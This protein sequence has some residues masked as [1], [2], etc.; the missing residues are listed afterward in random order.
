MAASE[1]FTLEPRASRSATVGELIAP[2]AWTEGSIEIVYA[3]RAQR[4]AIIAGWTPSS[5]S[6]GTSSG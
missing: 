5:G 6:S 4:W 3:A 1:R 2:G